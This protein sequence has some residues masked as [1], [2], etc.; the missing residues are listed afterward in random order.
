MK[1]D[2]IHIFLVVLILFFSLTIISADT[3][4]YFSDLG[5]TIPQGDCFNINLPC[6]NCTY[7]NISISLPNGT[8]IVENE[9]M[10]NLSSSYSY[11]YTLCD[12][13]TL[14][15]YFLITNYDED[16]VSLYSDTNFLQVT[17]NG[18]EFSIPVIAAF[19]ILLI[20]ISVL[21]ILCIYKLFDVNSPMWIITFSVI[22][23]FLMLLL[24]F[25]LWTFSENYLYGL[26]WIVNLFNIMFI[27]CLVL[28]FPFIIFLFGY[29]LFGMF[30]KKNINELVAMGYSPEEAKK[31]SRR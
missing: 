3:S 10:T 16:G 12:T 11:N 29:I 15:T 23:Y 6:N 30:N 14:G 2:N 4:L 8:T 7:M 26:I 25:V 18:E 1:K 27:V 19:G 21:L 24:L 22:A 17:P 5:L 31:Y 20:L 13:D 9:R 28:M